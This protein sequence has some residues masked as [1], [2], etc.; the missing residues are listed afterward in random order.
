MKIISFSLL[1]LFSLINTS[2]SFELSK[3]CIE[4]KKSPDCVTCS[5][6]TE[7]GKTS[8]KLTQTFE[9]LNFLND[10][11]EK[12]S[13]ANSTLKHNMA[14]LLRALRD[15]ETDPNFK[16]SKKEIN[17]IKEDF[18]RLTVLSKESLI[19]EKKFNY[20]L[21]NCSA[22]W[23]LN[24]Q[25]ELQQVQKIKTA[26][27]VKRPILA[28]KVFEEK[29]ANLSDK[30]IESKDLF[31]QN[32]FEKDLKTALLSNLEKIDDR[33]KD[34]ARFEFDGNRPFIRKGNE[35]YTKEY[36]QDI[37]SRFPAI[38]E[39]LVKASHYDGSIDHASTQETVCLFEEQFKKY[40]DQ[41][42]YKEMA[43]DAGLFLL[44]LVSGPLGL[45]LVFAERMAVWGL[46]ASEIKNALTA[47]TLI[48][49]TGLAANNIE[50]LKSLSEECRRGE[51]EFLSHSSEQSLETFKKCQ[52]KFGE[53]LFLSELGFIA[54]GTSN[55]SSLSLKFLKAGAKEASISLSEVKKVSSTEDISKYIYGNG[56]K[57]LKPGQIG[58]EFQTTDHGVFSV[59]DLKNIAESKNVAI[60]KIPQDYWRYVGNVYS[61]RLNLTK[62]EIENFIKSS[63]EMSPRTKLVLN[64][65]KSPLLGP[66]KINGGVGIVSA[67]AKGELLPLEKATG[68]KIARAAD[69]KI[70]EIVRLTVGKDVEAAKMSEALIG[71][72]TSL[73]AEDK[74]ISRI[75]IFTS[76]VH[77]RLYKRM[78]V[79]ADKI[80]D[81]DKRDV[82]IEMNQADIEQILKNM[83]LSK[84]GSSLWKLLLK[85]DS[86]KLYV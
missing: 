15:G 24:L 61:E 86:Y 80:K 16:E 45:E 44:P 25:D 35:S 73:I 62:T 58:L 71:Q 22:M 26:L 3:A 67:K 51:V 78:G 31:T 41:K 53:K 33:G 27:F 83:T 29:M 63:I 66:M 81:L 34:Y 36:I 76:K 69:E 38:I 7:G 2:E 48:F 43:L 28:N 56:L 17:E 46:K 8:S 74:S 39:D 20:C 77:A 70:V 37:T 65:E 85:T 42:F 54:A 47:S 5:V 59:M 49:Q 68:F 57:E 52:Q 14:P 1:F 12:L 55:I 11:V 6:Q 64:T 75:F 84:K 18:D 32:D 10:R 23:K 82:I 21:F 30:F 9:Q 72:A 79:P 60:Q 13:K 50:S 40:S 19:L 4:K